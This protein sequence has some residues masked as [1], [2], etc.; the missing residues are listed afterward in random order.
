ME[1]DT[2]AKVRYAWYRLMGSLPADYALQELGEGEDDVAYVYLTQGCRNAQLWMLDNGYQG[3]RQRSDALSWTGSD[4]TTGG[5]Y[6]DLPSDFLQ[7]D[8]NRD[9]SALVQANG[10]RWGPQ[11]DS[12]DDNIKG[13][14]FYILGEEIW[15][16]RSASPPSTLYMKYHY[17]HP[18]W[19]STVTIDFPMNARSLIV[20]E[21]ADSAMNENWF[22]GDNE[23]RAAINRMLLKAQAKTRRFV[24]QTKQSRQWRKPQR[25]GGRF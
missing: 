8:G 16:A 19:T 25:L 4:A 20:A 12:K 1:L 6:D 3:W 24:R 7:L 22:I 11:I 17:E 14:G 13:N 9:R 23:E 15:L 10:D 18:A 2:V 21:A 5:R